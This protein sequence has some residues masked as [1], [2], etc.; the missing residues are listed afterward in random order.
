LIIA[1]SI[2]SFDN[3]TPHPSLHTLIPIFG[4]TLIIGFASSNDLFVK[5]LGSKPLVWLGLVSYSAYLWHFPIFAFYRLG[6]ETLSGLN[7]YAMIILTFALAFLS[8]FFIEKPF[9]KSVSVKFFS[10]I[11]LLSCLLILTLS[12]YTIYSNGFENRLG[13]N[14][15]IIKSAEPNYLFG[16]DGCEKKVSFYIDETQFC[17]FGQINNSKIDF[18][19][20]GD[21][22]AMQAQTLLNDIALKNGLKGIY[23]GGSG[24]IPLLGIYPWRGNPHPN[25]ESKKC[26]SYMQKGFEFVKNNNIKTVFLIARWDYYVD[27]ANIRA[28]NPI[29][30]TSLIIGDDI[31]TIRQNSRQI[32]N[33]AVKRTFDAYNNLDTRLVVMLQAPH[34]NINVKN[35][36]ESII[37]DKNP[38]QKINEALDRGVLRSDHLSRQ[39]EASSKWKELG[40][41]FKNSN[42]IIIDPT[43]DF[44]GPINC[45]FITDEYSLY[46]D[47]DHASE[48]GFK[49]LELKFFKA[50]GL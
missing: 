23:G 38:M 21:S 35:F 31:D 46:T 32:Y 4:I 48:L 5:V 22:H 36:L 20:L 47:F 33:D 24:C 16:D 13:F 18:M 3:T 10:L 41:T 30:D 14:S 17:N 7:E 29:S 45:P 42:F 19:L 40:T 2:F 12:L 49:K 26:Y 6:V 44:C 37:D 43:D 27:G 50:L 28:F 11:T 25:D 1:Y 39:I 9:R 8:Y 34:Q 15:K